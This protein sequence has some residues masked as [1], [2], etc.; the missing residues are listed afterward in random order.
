MK[1][2]AWMAIFPILGSMVYADSLADAARRERERREKNKGTAEAT[3]IREEEL[4]AGRGQASKGTFSSAAASATDAAEP[5]AALPAASTETSG[6]SS[7]AGADATRAAARRRLEQSY[8]AI[9]QNAFALMRAVQLYQ[10][11]QGPQQT[12]AMQSSCRQ[13]LLGIGSLAF[14]IGARMQDAEEAARQGWLSPGEVRDARRRYRMD[15]SYWDQLVTLVR[16][17]RR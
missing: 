9:A 15:D 1:A 14:A 11:C 16:T 17:Y 12:D 2:S 3:V 4:V 8:A 13:K 5:D 6:G 7:P 10:G